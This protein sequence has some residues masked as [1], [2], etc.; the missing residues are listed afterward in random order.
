VCG[1]DAA[2]H[3]LNRRNEAEG[4]PRLEMGIAVHTGEVI[5]GNVGSER[6]TKYGVVGSAV[7][8]AGRIESFTVGGQVLISEAAL[9]AAGDGA[10]EV[11]SPL[12]IDAKGTREPI[13]VHD[14]RGV[15]GVRVP[16]AADHAVALADPINVLCHV[17]VG[18][19]VEAEAFGARLLELSLRGGTLLTPRRLRALS[20]LKMEV[21][22]L[23]RAPVVLY[24]KVVN[25]APDGT[26]GVRFTSLPAEVDAWLREVVEAEE[27]R[28][29]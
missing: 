12:S 26:M 1:G 19:K 23:G 3:E 27:S 6:R 22:P 16:D 9:R 5:L 7:N 13:V 11:G 10:V 25:V 15:A 4:L 2:G 8:H 24:S 14:L 21:R 20:N 29:R 18:K 17:V 28:S